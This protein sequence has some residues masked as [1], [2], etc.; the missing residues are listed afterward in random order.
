MF[1]SASRIKFTLCTKLGNRCFC[2]FPSAMLVAI[3][4]GTSIVAFRHFFL[5]KEAKENEK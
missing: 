5:F 1:I 3:Q 4:V 2:W